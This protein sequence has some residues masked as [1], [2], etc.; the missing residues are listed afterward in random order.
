MRN[1]VHPFCLFAGLST[2]R[3]AARGDQTVYCK[4]VIPQFFITAISRSF[5][6]KRGSL[7]LNK[8]ARML[9]IGVEE[10]PK[11]RVTLCDPRWMCV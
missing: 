11:Q 4:Q 8:S 2:S 1:D 5:T 9:I 6:L 10:K 3:K 7:N